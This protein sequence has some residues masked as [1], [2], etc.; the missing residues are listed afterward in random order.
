[1][2]IGGYPY[3][4]SDHRIWFQFLRKPCIYARRSVDTALRSI[5]RTCLGLP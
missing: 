2:I 3:G 4:N 1:M 5:Q